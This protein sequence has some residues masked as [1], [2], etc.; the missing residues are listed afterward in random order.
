MITLAKRE[1]NFVIGAACF[2]VVFFLFKS[3]IIP[4]FDKKDRM[5][6]GI[7]AKQIELEEMVRLSGEYEAY[8]GNSQ[9]IE[10]VLGRR[11]KGFA[12]RTFLRQKAIEAGVIIERINVFPAKETG[13][14]IESTMEVRL[15]AVTLKQLKEYL[16]RIES[17]EDLVSVPTIS[18]KENKREPGYHDVT[19]RALTFEEM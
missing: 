5:R 9:G 11:R 7:Q 4:F 12:L 13:P 3:L 17:P 19:L 6:K 10:Q 15:E 18:I 8:K 16:Y 2:I 14:F 1:K